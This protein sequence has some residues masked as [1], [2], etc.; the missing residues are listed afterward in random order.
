MLDY[1]VLNFSL[2]LGQVFLLPSI[3]YLE[4]ALLKIFAELIGNMVYYLG[5]STLGILL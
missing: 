5:N 2:L 4:D 3:F 1:L